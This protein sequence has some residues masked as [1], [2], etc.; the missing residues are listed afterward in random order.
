MKTSVTMV[1]KV[2]IAKTIGKKMKS[3]RLISRNLKSKGFSIQLVGLVWAI[4]SSEFDIRYMPG[5]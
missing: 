2:V 4:S 1:P 5:E 3:T